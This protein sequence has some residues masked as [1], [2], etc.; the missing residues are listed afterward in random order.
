MKKRF[1]F[2]MLCIVMLLPIFASCDGGETESSN[3]SSDVSV[4]ES[5]EESILE[6]VSFVVT[7]ENKDKLKIYCPKTVSAKARAAA[8][9]LRTHIRKMTGWNVPLVADLLDESGILYIAVGER[10]PKGS[11][12]RTST[13]TREKRALP[14]LKRATSSCLWVTTTATS[15]EHSLL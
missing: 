1:V 10:S 8:N 5:K 15:T 12:T 6:D 4:E 9:D 3:T 14:F 11:A 13:A 7:S 2:L